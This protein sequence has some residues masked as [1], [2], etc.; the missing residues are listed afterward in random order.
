MKQKTINNIINEL[1]DIPDDKAP[2][3]IQYINFVKWENEDLTPTEVEEIKK[4]RKEAKTEEGVDWRRVRSD[5][6]SKTS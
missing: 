4:A 3:I 1:E 6:W 2:N 5:V